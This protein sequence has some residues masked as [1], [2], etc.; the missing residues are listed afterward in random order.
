MT[1]SER[2]L[3]PLLER[4]RV[5]EIDPSFLTTHTMAVDDACGG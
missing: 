2:H 5:G 1:G 4:I 3:R